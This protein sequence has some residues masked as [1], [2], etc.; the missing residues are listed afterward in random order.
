MV[1][2][3]GAHSTEQRRPRGNLPL[4]LTSFVGRQ[5][6]LA[7]VATQLE[8][9]RLLTLTGAGGSGK[10]RLA[11]RLATTVQ[12]RFKD[13]V[14]WVELAS[15]SDPALVP[16]VTAQAL[17]VREVPGWSLTELL[18]EHLEPKNALLVLDNCEHLIEACAALAE[19]L[20]R[21]CPEVRVLATSRGAL[22][23]AGEIAWLVPPLSLPHPED[24]G[25]LETL[26][27]YEAVR[28]FAERAKAVISTFE[29]TEQNAPAIARVCHRLDGIP[30]AIE[31]AAARAKVLSVEQIAGR[32]EDSFRLLTGGGRTASLRHRTLRATMDWSHEL[33]S[34]DERVLFRRLATFAGGF[35]LEAAEQVCAGEGLEQDDVLDLLS[36]LVDKSLV[37]VGQRSGEVRCG[38][39]ETMRQY[40]Q[41]RL[42]ESEEAAAIAMRHASFFLQLAEEAEPA[43]FGPEQTAWLERLEREH[44]NLRAALGWIREKKEAE[45]GLRLAGALGRFWWFRD[46]YTEGRRW[47]EEFL[48]L[49]GA[50]GRTAVRAKALHAHGALIHR[51]ADYSARDQEVARSR[52]EES[53]EIYRNLGDGPRAAAV[54]VYLGRLAAGVSD[55]ERARSSLEESLR[56]EQESGNEYGI[57]V[58]R[59]YLGL[60]ALLRGEH[61]PAARTH[62][63]ESLGILRELGG[64]D[65]IKACLLFLG[66]LAC[67]QGDYATAHA[68]F[69][70]LMEDAPLQLYRYAAPA[71]LEGCARL[72]AGEGQA[73]RALKLAGAADV[74]QQ[75]I[76]SS[77]GPAYRAYVRR[78]LEPAWQALGEKEGKAAWE[79]GRSMTLEQAVAYAQEQPPKEER[80][81]RLPAEASVA[82]PAGALSDRELEVLRLVTEGMTDAQV[83]ERLFVSTRTVNAH[84]RSILRKLGAR[85]RATAARLAEE[86]GLLG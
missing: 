16:K 34:E 23:V 11:L 73:A 15:L 71:V 84:M 81:A 46:Y 54:L 3:P 37:V 58:T 57:A 8:E 13:G 27:H 18:I 75:T 79:K 36:R 80:D 66:C 22:G 60:L 50:S 5:K 45:Q 70:E 51:S 41:E 83:A 10:T 59:T 47:L 26:A 82:N 56:L 53:I 9:T 42:G 7:E 25:D 62:L 1:N 6:E 19:T 21:T 44:A 40:G 2:L 77:W 32:L 65:D 20:L 48:D 29:L 4:E 72:A 38:L 55:W 24:P 64:T 67:D 28:L 31:L 33:L 85:S 30:L 86:R 39:L 43:M 69:A 12:G 63:E 61:G 17:S 52:L 74:L 68:R 76:G 35:T 49:P 78:G 14:W